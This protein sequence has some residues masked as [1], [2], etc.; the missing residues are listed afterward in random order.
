[1][2]TGIEG[3]N[4]MMG[5]AAYGPER[6]SSKA[7]SLLEALANTKPAASEFQVMNQVATAPHR[8]APERQQPREDEPESD[9]LTRVVAETNASLAVTNRSLRFRINRETDDI[10]IQVVDTE[11]DRVIRS[12]PTD[13][14]INLAARMRELSGIGA[15]VDQSR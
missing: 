4:K 14:M 5:L 12:I 2:S 11:R 1:M 10:Q 15:M 9:N 13:E 3:V 8:E 7:R 6:T